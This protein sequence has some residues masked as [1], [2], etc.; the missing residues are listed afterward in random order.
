MDDVGMDDRY[1]CAVWY[2]D[3][4][5]QINYELF[6]AEKEAARVAVYYD[7]DGTVLGLQLADGS[8]I[9]RNQWRMFADA[10]R[11]WLQAAQDRR[12]NPPPP[13]PTRPSQDP[14]EG[15]RIDIELS[16]PEWL[17]RQPTT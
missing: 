13:T 6:G 2:L 14:F 5:S 1:T 17:G 12:D 4:H 9:P 10:K 16:E 8:T 11:R 7:G 15:C 3:D